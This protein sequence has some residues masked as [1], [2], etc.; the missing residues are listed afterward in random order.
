M[1]T[2]ITLITLF[3]ISFT[4]FGQSR[5]DLTPINQINATQADVVV[6]TY[7]QPDSSFLLWN[8]YDTILG[9]S[10]MAIESGDT[11]FGMTEW[12]YVSMHFMGP[13]YMDV[14][15][16]FLASTVLLSPIQSFHI[17]S[18]TSPSTPITY[19]G[20]IEITFD[21]PNVQHEFP[22]IGSFNSNLVF[23]IQSDVVLTTTDS[24]TYRLTGFGPGLV[25]ISPYYFHFFVGD[26]TFP[27]C[28]NELLID[29]VYSYPT[30][31]CNGVMGIVPLNAVGPVTYYW[32]NASLANVSMLTDLCQGYYEILAIDSLLNCNTNTGVLLNTENPFTVNNPDP[33]AIDFD[34][35]TF[36]FANCDFDF[37]QPID[38]IHYSEVVDTVSNVDDY[39]FFTIS[40]FSNGS[41]FE[42]SSGFITPNYHNVILNVYIYCISTD[43]PIFQAKHVVVNTQQALILGLD[44]SENKFITIFPNPTNDLLYFDD[45]ELSGELFNS[46]GQ[47]VLIFNGSSV[48]L[49][50]LTSG[51]YYLK[52]VGS[53]TSYKIIKQ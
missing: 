49:A 30:N 26:P 20:S 53:S 24:I 10:S 3:V 45:K 52:P 6:H 27:L 28:N 19:D 13:D 33:N 34:T 36:I 22:L 8:Y 35:V 48:S 9:S 32:N 14:G 25:K 46:L 4:S 5:I 16:T 7:N 21:N 23:E 29:R 40:V 18:Y 44:K 1:K 43:D 37:S 15:T 17:S 38:S 31:G 41:V 2:W 12:N 51:I 11:I 50:E 47:S 39:V 42:A